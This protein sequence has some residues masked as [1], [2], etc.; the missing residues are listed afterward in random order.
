MFLF[1]PQLPPVMS[2]KRRFG[3]SKEEL[4]IQQVLSP[5]NSQSTLSDAPPAPGQKLNEVSLASASLSAECMRDLA[6]MLTK[7]MV[8]ALNQSGSS[9]SRSRQDQLVT[10]EQDD[11][12]SDQWSDGEVIDVELPTGR[13]SVA[14][15]VAPS[16]F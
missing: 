7:S 13:P 14:S 5:S 1:S 15:G 2:Q 10:V 4:E 6:S 8:E 16:F 9:R 12:A 3:L 11:Y